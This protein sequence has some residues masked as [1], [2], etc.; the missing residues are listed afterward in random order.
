MIEIPDNQ[1]AQ[2]RVPGDL[3]LHPIAVLAILVVVVNDRVL[4]LNYPSVI[5]GKLSDFAGL[6]Y[7]PLFVVSLFEVFRWIFWRS[8]W[9][10]S[11]WWVTGVAIT[12]GACFVL[13]KTWDPAGEI[14]R[15]LVGMMLWPARAIASVATGDPPPP[16]R[17]VTMY[18]DPTDLF[19]LPSLLIPV[20]IA[21][22]VMRGATG[23]TRRSGGGR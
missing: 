2:Q 22:H 18:K 15:P 7:F 5:S 16:V 17:G 3:L 1:I 11:A 6:I 9:Q 10:L 20:W 23:R 4:K 14:Y 19:A 13:M 12:V 21:F 8:R